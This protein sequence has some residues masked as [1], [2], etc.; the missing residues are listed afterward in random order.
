MFKNRRAQIEN[1]QLMDDIDSSA[2]K[3]QGDPLLPQRST[4]WNARVAAETRVPGWDAPFQASRSRSALETAAHLAGRAIFGGYF[5]YNGINHFKSRGML[6]GYARS[7]NV[8]AADAA[9]IGSGL[10]LVAGGI[11]LLAGMRPKLGSA[12][13]A[14]FLLGVSPMMHA[15]WNE[16]DPQQRMNEMINFTKN[17]ALVGGALLAAGHPE[18]W[19]ASVR[20]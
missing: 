5:L 12:S 15:Y 13:V 17:M 4:A 1:T 9:V 16:T 6:A 18:P 19:P 3:P 20:A 2:L 10:M 11:S 14:G 7:K 8:P